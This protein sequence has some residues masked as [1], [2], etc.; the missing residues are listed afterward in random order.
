MFGIYIVSNAEYAEELNVVY[1]I[2]GSLPGTYII[3]IIPLR[4]KFALV[5]ITSI[6]HLTTRALDHLAVV[7]GDPT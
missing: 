3:R 7:F 1:K 4:T 5:G 2:E 6:P